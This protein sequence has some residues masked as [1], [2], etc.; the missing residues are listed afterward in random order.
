MT[1]QDVLSFRYATPE[2]NAIF[3]ERGKIIAERKLWIAVMRA[4]RELGIDIPLEEIKKFEAVVENVDLNRIEELERESRHDVNARIKA[5]IEIAGAREYIHRGMTSRDLTDNVEQMQIKAAVS[6][7]LGKAVSVARHLGEK[8][9][10]YRHIELTS[11]THHQPAQLTLLG[12][13]LSMTAEELVYGVQRLEE[14]LAAYPLRGIKGPVG[15]QA[16]MLKYLGSNERV[17]ALEKAVAAHLGFSTVLESPGQIYPR[18]LDFDLASRLLLI[19]AAYSNFGLNMRLM[20]GYELAT[21]GFKAGQVGSSAMPH[22][23]NT[24]TSE[25]INGMMKILRMNTFGLSELAGEQWEEG[26][27]SDS[28]PRRVMIPALF[29]TIDGM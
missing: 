2:M 6:L 5:F 1:N 14:F 15:T 26:D 20:S 4:Q 24:R 29:Y 17:Q 12:R 9:D 10:K 25:R 7:I 13:R 22:K 18:S 3:S 23:M 16:D 8:A 21:E 11:R 19:G 28:S 27:V